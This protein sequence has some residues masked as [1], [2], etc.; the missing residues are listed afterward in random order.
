MKKTGTNTDGARILSHVKSQTLSVETRITF[1]C[2]R[3]WMGNGVVLRGDTAVMS[4]CFRL[5]CGRKVSGS[6]SV[7]IYERFKKP[8]GSVASV[9]LLPFGS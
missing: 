3:S 4:F 1:F 6:A 2:W 8:S 9:V 7:C 5:K